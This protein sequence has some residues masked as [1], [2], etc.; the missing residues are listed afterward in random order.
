MASR[1]HQMIQSLAYCFYLADGCPQGKA[2]QHWLEA[3]QLVQ[4]EEQFEADVFFEPDI[5]GDEPVHKP[6]ISGLFVE[7]RCF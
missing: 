7:T 3:E 1:E 4:G 2:V 6:E 5:L